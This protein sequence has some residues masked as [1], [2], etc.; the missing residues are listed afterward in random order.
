MTLHFPV[1]V[2]KRSWSSYFP[3]RPKK[4]KEIPLGFVPVAS[5]TSQEG[6]GSSSVSKAL[7]KKSPSETRERKKRSAGNVLRLLVSMTK[8]FCLLKLVCCFFN[9][10]ERAKTVYQKISR[11]SLRTLLVRSHQQDLPVMSP[12]KPPPLFVTLPCYRAMKGREKET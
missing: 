5:P 2:P 8:W 3:F 7:P 6:K 10:M 4:K 9:F 11:K 12:T 1:S